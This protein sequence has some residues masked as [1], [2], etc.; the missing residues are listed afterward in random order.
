MDRRAFTILAS[1][2]TG[3]LALQWTIQFVDAF[4][5]MERRLQ[6]VSAAPV[7]QLT[8]REAIRAALAGW[9]AADARAIALE[10]KV[11]VMAPSVAALDR[12]SESDGSLCPT[13]AAKVLKIKPRKFTAWLRENGWVYSRGGSNKMIGRSEKVDQ[14]LL[15]HKCYVTQNSDGDE[16]TRSQV[17]VTS[18]GMAKLGHFQRDG[19]AGNR[20]HHGRV[21][22]EEP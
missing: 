3:K 1:K 16:V 11:A 12:I 20:I 19:K 9:D 5:A 17:M 21:S 14:D 22:A 15:E 7:A 18:K 2:F 13:D 10:A 4:D 8:E 6:E